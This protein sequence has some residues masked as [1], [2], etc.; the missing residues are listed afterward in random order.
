MNT[1]V[2]LHYKKIQYFLIKIKKK[3]MYLLAL[4]NSHTAWNLHVSELQLL[5]FPTNSV[6]DFNSKQK[7]EISF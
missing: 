3:Y 1:V 6:C 2:I 4:N 7:L 5:K